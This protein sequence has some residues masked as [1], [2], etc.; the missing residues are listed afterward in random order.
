MLYPLDTLLK[1]SFFLIK[2][3]SCHHF[4]HHDL[5][6]CEENPRRFTVGVP[7]I[8]IYLLSGVTPRDGHQSYLLKKGRFWEIS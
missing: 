1:V 3:P 4:S 6:P 7:N 2:Q 5:I 8:Y